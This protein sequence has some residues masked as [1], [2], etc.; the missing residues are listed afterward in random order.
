MRKIQGTCGS[1]TVALWGCSVPFAVL[2]LCR[3]GKEFEPRLR[4][5]CSV[6]PGRVPGSECRVL[7]R[8]GV[9]TFPQLGVSFIYRQIH[10]NWCPKYEPI[11]LL[12]VGVGGE[13][14]WRFPVFGREGA[15]NKVGLSWAFSGEACGDANVGR[16]LV[17]ASPWMS[18]CGK[19]GEGPCCNH[20]VY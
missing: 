10:R 11:F 4:N 3:T 9:Q 14:M 17:N 18:V 20:H 5:W 8:F 16:D 6:S 12:Q 13:T 1:Y 19:R 15:F 2:F 7:L